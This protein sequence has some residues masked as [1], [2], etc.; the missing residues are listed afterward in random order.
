M[1]LPNR[2]FNSLLEEKIDV[3]IRG[4]VDTAKQTF[5][6]QSGKLIHPGEFGKYRESCCGSGSKQLIIDIPGI[7]RSQNNNG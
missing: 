2:I 5:V 4:F 7:A 1:L 3:F 6:D